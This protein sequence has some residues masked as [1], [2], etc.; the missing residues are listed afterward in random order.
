M[1]KPQPS[2]PKPQPAKTP[3]ARFALPRSAPLTRAR[4]ALAAGDSPVL[5]NVPDGFD[6]LVVA[7]LARALAANEG[8]ATLVHVARDAGRSAAFR[9]GL[10][11]VAPEIETLVL[12]AWDCQPYDRV[13]PNA[14]VAAA[15][16]TALSRLTRSRATAEAPRILCTTVDALVQRVPARAR[17]SVET[18]SAAIGNVLPMDSVTQWVEANGYLRTGTVRDTGEYALRGGIL[19]LAPPGL[20]N[21]IRLDF[22]GDTL[23]SIRAFDR[24]TQRSTRQLPSVDLL[25]VSEVLM[26]EGAVARFR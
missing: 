10:A 5:G 3:P 9:N 15:R 20:P 26:G 8:P 23:E 25:P 7:D 22:F 6:A 19:D 2:P 17:M 18:F 1:A 4:D 16:M 14:A 24:E 11:F 21:P 12:P 13:S